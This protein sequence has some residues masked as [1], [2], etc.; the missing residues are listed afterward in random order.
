MIVVKKSNDSCGGD[1]SKIRIDELNRRFNR[2]NLKLNFDYDNGGDGE[3]G[4]D[5][6]LIIIDEDDDD[7]CVNGIN[8]IELFDLYQGR[9]IDNE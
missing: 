8:D 3:D 6:D 1:D 9:H 2:L 5:D 4:D 7:E